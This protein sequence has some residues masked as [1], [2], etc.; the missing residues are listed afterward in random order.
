MKDDDVT[1]RNLTYRQFVELGRAPTVHDIAAF[2]GETSDDVWSG[3]QRLH[4]EHALVLQSHAGELRMANPFSAVPTAYRVFADGRWWY[5]N[6][7]GDPHP[8]RAH[9]SVL[10]PFRRESTTLTRMCRR[11]GNRRR[12]HQ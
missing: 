1:L 2:S 3:W 10:E 8:P 12:T 6:C 11:L 9:R 4:D 7:A 5:A